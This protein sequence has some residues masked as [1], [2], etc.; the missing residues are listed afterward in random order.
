[1]KKVAVIGVGQ[2]T[3]TRRKEETTMELVYE[4]S[5]KALA[6][7]KLQ[8]ND[9]DAVVYG[10]ALDGFDGIHRKG[11]NVINSSCGKLKPF[12]RCHVGGATGVAA[13]IAGYWHVASGA[14]KT[15]LVVCEEK[16]SPCIPHAQALFR[17]IFDEMYD[18]PLNPN[19]IM[20]FALEMNRYMHL[21]GCTKKHCALVSVKNKKNA[22]D[23]PYAQLPEEITVDDVLNSPLLVYPVNRLD[24]S[25]VSDGA[26]AAVLTT[27]D[28]AKKIKD[29]V[30]CFAGVGWNMDSSYWTNRDLCYPLY[31]ELASK[32]AYK[33][34]KIKN[35]RKEI[36]VAEIY[37]PFSY[38]ELQHSEGLGFAKKGEGWKLIEEGISYRDGELPINP[39]GGLLGVGNPIAAGGMQ[40]F[41]E[42]VLQLLGDAGKR[43][44]KK[45]KL[46]TGVC[47]AWG[48]LMQFS[49]VIVLR[50][51][52]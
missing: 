12:M 32:Q 33:M 4:A 18:R 47:H 16:M 29:K 38:K 43:Q 52:R 21:S 51:E 28:I 11:E 30:V 40:K 13:P 19:L 46:Q 10:S 36:D 14:F 5:S 34:A 45:K 50:R 39:S 1:M 42:V 22:I 9:I 49:T 26:A 8:I 37:D 6:D 23:N 27:F 48:G 17:T 24:V 44:V 25:P 41:N 31:L 35:P 15:V 7:A 2:T 20:L 3:Y